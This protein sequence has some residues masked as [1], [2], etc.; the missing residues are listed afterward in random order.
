MQA[1]QVSTLDSLRP[2]RL[3]LVDWGYN[4]G[5]ERRRAAQNER[6]AVIDVARFK[7]LAGV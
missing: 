4:T 5:P 2:W 3:W 1:L 7:E 6:I